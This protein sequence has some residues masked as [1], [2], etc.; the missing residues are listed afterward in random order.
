[1]FDFKYKDRQINSIF[2]SIIR[3]I[4][5]AFSIQS[6]LFF[7]LESEIFDKLTQIS[8]LIK[9]KPVSRRQKACQLALDDIQIAPGCYFLPSNPENIL[10]KLIDCKS[11]QSVNRAPYLARFIVQKIS[12]SELDD[13]ILGKK[14]IKLD[15]NRQAEIACIFKA[16]DDLRQDILALQIMQFM[17]NVFDANG[18]PLFLY[19]YK[20]VATKPGS[21]IIECVPNAN[22][23]DLIGRETRTDL[24]KYFISKVG[25]F[26]LILAL[27]IIYIDF[28][29]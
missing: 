13:F 3:D 11:M 27:R 6:K 26:I 12:Q 23:R 1:M 25:T 21:G 2:D 8:A 4:T 9:S 7:Q 22:S 28:I 5:N 19:P 15:L 16:D 24:Y 29:I 20:V 14:A 10:V 18:L 17:K